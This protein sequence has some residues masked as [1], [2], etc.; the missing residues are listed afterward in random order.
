MSW[1]YIDFQKWIEI[2]C[3]KDIAERVNVFNLRGNRLTTL[4]DSISLL[5]NLRN[6]NLDGNQLTSLARPLCG[7]TSLARPLCGLTTLPNSIS[8]LTN[9]RELVL[10]NNQLT[11]SPIQFPV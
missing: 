5:I 2:G 6:L 3:P 1:Y 9:L 11:L 10:R 8:L 7:L 4:P